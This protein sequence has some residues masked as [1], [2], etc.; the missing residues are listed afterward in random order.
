MNV[1]IVAS[2]CFS[3]MLAFHTAQRQA[4]NKISLQKRKLPYIPIRIGVKES[5]VHKGGMNL[6]G[7]LSGDHSQMLLM[8]IQCKSSP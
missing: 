2:V 5:A 7:E 4:C 3:T 1:Y 6:F 8:T